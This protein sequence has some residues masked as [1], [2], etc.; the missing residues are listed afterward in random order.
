[1]NRKPATL[2]ALLAACSA[3]QKTHPNPEQIAMA[4]QLCD[5]GWSAECEKLRTGT[6]E[7]SAD[8]P[9]SPSGEPSIWGM[10]G[11]AILEGAVEGATGAAVG[12]AF[13]GGGGGGSSSPG[14]YGIYGRPIYTG[15]R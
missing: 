11:W 6:V 13:S 7:D 5:Q 1:M 2:L 14:T 12:S 15:N 4:Q 8:T 9:A 10:I 3:A